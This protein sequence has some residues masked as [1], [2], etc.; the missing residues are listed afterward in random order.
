LAECEPDSLSDQFLQSL[1]VAAIPFFQDG[2]LYMDLFADGGTMRFGAAGGA[3][4]TGTVTYL[5]RIALPE[6]AVVQVEIRDTSLADAPA[7]TIGVQVI[8]TNGRQVPIPYVVRYNPA[9]IVENHTYTMSARISDSEG[10]LLFINDTAIPVITNDNPTE[11]VEILV[12]QT[13]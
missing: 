3:A 8:H 2:K 13:G 9:V 7:E 10:N 12:V 6:D 5:Q 4:V 11:N 1:G